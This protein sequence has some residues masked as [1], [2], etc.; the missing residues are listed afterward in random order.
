MRQKPIKIWQSRIGVALLTALAAFLA[1]QILVSSHAAKFGE[2]P[3]DHN[4]KACVISLVSH[5]GD[6]VITSTAFVLSVI[7]AI[8]RAGSLSAQSEAAA[9]AIRSAHPRGPPLN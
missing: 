7:V 9:I 4:G 3:H 5:G 8:W 6:K 1:A 2:G